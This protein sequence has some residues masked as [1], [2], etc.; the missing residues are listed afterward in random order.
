MFSSIHN[1]IQVFYL[2]ISGDQVCTKVHVFFFQQEICKVNANKSV[3][4][5]GVLSHKPP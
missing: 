5:L 4:S 2:N 1:Y 3:M